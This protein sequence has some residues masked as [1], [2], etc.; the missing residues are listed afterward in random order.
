MRGRGGGKRM[1]EDEEERKGR[2]EERWEKMKKNIHTFEDL[3]FS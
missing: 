3:V 2:E 1:E